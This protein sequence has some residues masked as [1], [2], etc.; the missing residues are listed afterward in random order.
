[1]EAHEHSAL[2]AT[3]RRW[4]KRCTGIPI[5][6]CLADPFFAC[7]FNEML[8][9]LGC[10]ADQRSAV[11]VAASTLCN[12][13]MHVFVYRVGVF[14]EIRRVRP[15][16]GTRVNVHKQSTKTNRKKDH[17]AANN[18]A[19]P[20]LPLGVDAGGAAVLLRPHRTPSRS[21]S[22]SS[23]FAHACAALSAEARSLKLMNAQL[24]E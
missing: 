6:V 13:C 7:I 1:M 16:W 20:L 21:P 22:I 19:P 24:K 10:S 18:E 11:S 23:P 3:G 8:A 2:S 12:F 4:P 17:E 5:I 15:Q 14:L 9:W